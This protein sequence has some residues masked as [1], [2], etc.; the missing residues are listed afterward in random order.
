VAS[1]AAVMSGKIVVRERMA[2]PQTRFRGES[3]PGEAL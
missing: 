1:V 3:S 2:P